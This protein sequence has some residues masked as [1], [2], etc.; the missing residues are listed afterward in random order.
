MRA[1]SSSPRLLRSLLRSL[2]P[3]LVLAGVLARL[4]AEPDV[5]AELHDRRRIS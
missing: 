2:F 3:W 5:S 1:A 4:A